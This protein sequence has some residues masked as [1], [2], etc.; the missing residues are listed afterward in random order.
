[1]EKIKSNPCKS[2]NGIIRLMPRKNVFPIQNFTL[3]V[4][5]SLNQELLD[6][7]IHEN[8]SELVF[9][10]NG[11]GVHE[12][13]GRSYPIV[14]GDVFLVLGNESHC[15]SKGNGL[16]LV[17]IVFNWEELGIPKLDLGQITAFQSLFII[18]PTNVNLNRFDNRFRVTP[19]DF[20]SILHLIHKLD[21]LVNHQQ[22]S[23]GVRFRAMTYF[24]EIVTQLFEIYERNTDHNFITT[25]PHRLGALVAM[26]ERDYTKNITIKTMCQ[27]IGMSYATL[28]R[29]FKYYYHDS[30]INYLTNQRLRHAKELLCESP[31]L[32][33]SEISYQVGFLDSAYFSRKFKNRYHFSPFLYRKNFNK[34]KKKQSDD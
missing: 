20:N 27:K 17:N 19:D 31:H 10:T 16:S 2:R 21:H 1:M 7:H 5:T 30:P 14:T 18:D 28:F 22:K 4:Y 13:A 15:Y 9:I 6:Y 24:I 33:I 34:S 12:I 32:S 11:S 25:I 26:L 3:G 23:A 29:K 8:F